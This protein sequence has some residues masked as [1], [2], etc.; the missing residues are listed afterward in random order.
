MGFVIAQVIGEDTTP[1]NLSSVQGYLPTLAANYAKDETSGL[2]LPLQMK[3]NRL[4]VDAISGSTT[5]SELPS[6]RPRAFYSKV[7]INVAGYSNVTLLD[8]AAQ[9]ISRGQ[10]DFISVR[11]NEDDF[12]IELII[13]G[14]QVYKLKLKDLDDD[15]KLEG[16]DDEPFSLGIGDSDRHFFDIYRPP[17]DFTTN[18]VLKAHNTKSN[19]RRI[20]AWFVKMREKI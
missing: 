14:I 15:Y 2:F 4:K 3:S 16:D 6:F 20:Y 9:G 12:E 1:A 13:D 5:I 17:A 18:L 7:D 19:T 10:V 8:A 11:T